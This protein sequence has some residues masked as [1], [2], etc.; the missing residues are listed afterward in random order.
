M[1]GKPEGWIRILD[2]CVKVLGVVLL[3][4]FLLSIEA[5]TTQRVTISVFSI[6]QGFPLRWASG[7]RET[8][9]GHMTR[10]REFVVQSFW[11]IAAVPLLLCSFWRLLV[12]SRQRMFWFLVWLVGVGLAVRY[13]VWVHSEGYSSQFASDVGSID[14]RMQTVPDLV[15]YLLTGLVLALLFAPRSTHLPQY[16]GLR[17]LKPFRPLSWTCWTIVWL[18]FFQMALWEPAKSLGVQLELLGATTLSP[19][20]QLPGLGSVKT[21]DAWSRLGKYV[22]SEKHKVFGL[23][24][25]DLRQGYNYSDLG[26]SLGVIW[27]CA[28]VVLCLDSVRW[29]DV[30]RARNRFF[31]TGFLV[32]GLGTLIF[33]VSALSSA[34]SPILSQLVAG[35]SI[36][37]IVIWSLFFLKRKPRATVD[38]NVDVE[39]VLKQSADGWLL[40]RASLLVVTIGVLWLTCLWIM[41]SWWPENLWNRWLGQFHR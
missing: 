35:V 30:I 29:W 10:Q 5:M 36:V 31:R 14:L 9:F 40:P 1:S 2:L 16:V 4:M 25:P 7:L 3:G 26:D 28:A 39:V 12:S 23:A 20:V 24:P 37:G 11:G 19:A 41:G 21:D 34:I 27:M 18:S 22:L 17:Y 33:F 15:L 6:E 38:E 8:A 32:I 13:V